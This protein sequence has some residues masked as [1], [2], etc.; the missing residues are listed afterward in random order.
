MRL[1]VTLEVTW[2]TTVCEEAL[3]G[4]LGRPHHC[5]EEH[6]SAAVIPLSHWGSWLGCSERITIPVETDD[7]QG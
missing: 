1:K 5:R 2:C 7:T 6:E 4:G 3:R